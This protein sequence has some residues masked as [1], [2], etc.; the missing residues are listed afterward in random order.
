MTLADFPHG[1]ACI[2]TEVGEACGNKSRLYKLGVLP[3]SEV[4]ILRS[5]PLGDP[6]QVRVDGTLLSIRKR[7]AKY[8]NVE[9]QLNNP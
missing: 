6:L 7:D 5:A 8:I 9:E 4:E 1:K 3:G 2:I